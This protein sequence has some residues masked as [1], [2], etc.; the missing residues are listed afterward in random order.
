MFDFAPQI[1]IGAE[2]LS[3]RG[4]DQRLVTERPAAQRRRAKDAEYH[5]AR[6]AERE[7]EQFTRFAAEGL[8][9]DEPPE[10]DD[11]E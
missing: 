2:I 6:A 8:E 7:A 10:D 3:R 11:D 5:A 9:G 4:E 1:E